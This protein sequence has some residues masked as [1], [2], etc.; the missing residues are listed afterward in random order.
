[1]RTRLQEKADAGAPAGDR[2]PAPA[3]TMFGAYRITK[4][5]AAGASGAVIEALHLPTNRRVAMKL[6]NPETVGAAREQ[7]HAKAVTS[8]A[9]EAELLGRI[10]LPRVVTVF[11]A[12]PT[13]CVGNARGSPVV[14]LI[15]EST[16]SL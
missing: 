15:L 10:D 16:A 14:R 4:R 9:H 3:G 7:A 11:D 2:A 6:P 13:L 5:L 1:M 8:L 12:G